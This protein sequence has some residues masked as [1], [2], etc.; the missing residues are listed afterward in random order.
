M[1]RFIHYRLFAL[2][3]LLLLNRPLLFGFQLADGARP[4]P[5]T[6]DK[7]ILYWGNLQADLTRAN[8]FHVTAELTVQDFRQMLLHQPK[9][10]N[11]KVLVAQVVFRLDGHP[12]TATRTEQDYVT[13]LG[14]LDETF[15]RPATEGQVLH[16][17]DLRLD[18]AT[19]GSIDIRLKEPEQQPSKDVVVW[20]SNT[21]SMLNTQLLEQVAWGRED[22]LEISNRDFF[23]ENEFWQIIRLEPFVVWNPYVTQRE[24]RVSIRIATRALTE[25]GF[26]SMLE[27]NAYR[28][29][30][31]NVGNYKHLVRPGSLAT[32]TL[33]T[34]Q[35]DRLYEKALNIVADSDPRLTL[36]RNR[37]TH[38]LKI[39]WGALEQTLRNLYLIGDMRDLSGQ[40][41]SVDDP[42]DMRL[43][44]NFGELKSMLGQRPALW[45]DDQIVS[46]LGF[47]LSAGDWSV[48]IPPGE[49]MPDSLVNTDIPT[50]ATL[51][52][53]GLQASGYALGT[54]SFSMNFTQSFDFLLWPNRLSSLL[55]A[56]GSA[57]IALHPPVLQEK[58]YAVSFELKQETILSL[59]VFEPDGWNTWTL[60]E[61]Y[62]AG[63]HRVEIPRSVFRNSGKH[64]LFLNTPFGVARQEFEVR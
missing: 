10:W 24:V 48:Q 21:T 34:D 59:S 51:R 14:W 22:I 42:R 3:L 46:D 47:N 43:T 15:G 37:D 50:K 17:T 18:E 30:V 29:M 11:G 61:K 4:A 32:L 41:V 28:S 1:P 9:L 36:R 55:F 6:S 8:N 64:Y 27:S 58:V 13:R 62:I 35:H 19:T 63:Q 23:T 57:R 16:L 40:L 53:S 7:Y 20:Q 25:Q 26:V 5:N 49:Q 12:L 31:D 33:L 44:I 45:I 56:S 39:K 54:L 52:L 38:T 60:N 2:L